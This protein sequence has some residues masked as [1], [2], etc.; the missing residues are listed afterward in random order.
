MMNKWLNEG[1]KKKEEKN[2][3]NRGKEVVYFKPRN[4]SNNCGLTSLLIK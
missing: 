3:K 1:E 2:E 4:R